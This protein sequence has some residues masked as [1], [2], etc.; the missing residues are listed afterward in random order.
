MTDIHAMSSTLVLAL[1]AARREGF[2]TLL[3]LG[4]L[5]TYGVSPCETLDLVHDAM[6]REDAV[7]LLGNH[8]ALYREPKDAYLATLPDWLRET[9]A[10]TAAA[11]PDG[12][13]EAFAWH[14]EWS[15]GPLLAA[16]A[17]P[18]GANDWRYIDSVEKA[19]DA[20]KALAKRGFG[21]GIFG[22][23][24]RARRFDTRHGSVYTLGALGQ[25]RDD[26]ARTPQWA[27]I[28][29]DDE[30]VTVSPRDIPFDRAAHIAAIRATS[31]TPATQDRLCGFFA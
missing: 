15:F 3:I 22:H 2:D 6:S 26:R 18:Y 4:D 19:E 29:V 13:M 23:T 1:E 10:W 20:A 27:M 12:A 16:H 7:L 8:D 24:H 17:N 9:I 28:E 25:P 21:V 11:I 31:M 5:L 30:T 14:Q